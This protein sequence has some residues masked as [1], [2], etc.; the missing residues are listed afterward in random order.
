LIVQQV[1]DPRLV[2]GI[3]LAVSRQTR[4]KRPKSSITKYVS[5]PRSGGTIDGERRIT[6][7]R[8]RWLHLESRQRAGAGAESIGETP[9][10]G[11]NS[12]LGNYDEPMP[13]LGWSKE[14]SKHGKVLEL[15][16]ERLTALSSVA[17]H[18]TSWRLPTLS[19]RADPVLS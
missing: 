12:F 1:A 2:V 5:P 6:Q 14:Q 15:A 11:V 8:K 19:S 17:F 10:S 18:L 4:P 9:H 3:R 7:L 16:S 13:L